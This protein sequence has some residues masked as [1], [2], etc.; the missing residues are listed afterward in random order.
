MTINA[1]VLYSLWAGVDQ[2]YEI[3]LSGSERKG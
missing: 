1:E 2:T 3:C